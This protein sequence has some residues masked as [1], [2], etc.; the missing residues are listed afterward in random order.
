MRSGSGALSTWGTNLR[1]YNALNFFFGNIRP[2]NTSD[3]PKTPQTPPNHHRTY[4][5][6]NFFFLKT[7]ALEIPKTTPK[8]PKQHQNITV[9]INVRKNCLGHSPRPLSGGWGHVP[10]APPPPPPVQHWHCAIVHTVIGLNDRQL[11]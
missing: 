7:Y 5:A 9:H 6:L 11:F 4:N 1:T 10:P 3:L 2:R 8:H